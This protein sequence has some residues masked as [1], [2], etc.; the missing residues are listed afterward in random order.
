MAGSSS[1]VSFLIEDR[2]ERKKDRT[3]EKGLTTS[4]ERWSGKK[5]EGMYPHKPMLPMLPEPRHLY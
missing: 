3:G 4:L 2:D 5:V 1:F